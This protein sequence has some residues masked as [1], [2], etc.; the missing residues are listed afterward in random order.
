MEKLYADSGDKE[1]LKQA[2]EVEALYYGEVCRIDETLEF[3]R[4]M[5]FKKIG[6]AFCLGLRKEAKVVG[7]IFSREFDV[8]SVCCKVGGLRKEDFDMSERSWVGE[9]TCNPIEQAKILN[10]EKTEFN[11]AL[12]LCVG[13]DSLFFKYSEAPVTALVV[14]D[15]KLGHNPIA[16]IYCPYIKKDLGKKLTE[17]EE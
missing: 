5:F 6:I 14:K 11:I 4:R 7:E 10:A 15:R 3:A 12:G 13:H 8:H 1:I 16:A 17:K 9:V 2:S